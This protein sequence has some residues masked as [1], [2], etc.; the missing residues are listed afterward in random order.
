MMY[1]EDLTAGMEDAPPLDEDGIAR[2]GTPLE[3]S[4]IAKR[5]DV[6]TAM[7]TVFDPEI[8][9]NIYELGLVYTYD[10]KENGDVD[11]MMTLTAPGCPVAG[12]LPGHLAR[13]IAEV[14]GVGEVSV[15]LT[16]DPPWDPS[17]MSE[18]A[19]VELNMF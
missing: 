8:P 1:M 14:E 9:V 2:S 12:V 10:Q 4:E 19:R 3:N 16:W 17:M 15:Q 5:E 18:A 6:V 13:T 11:V 7:Q